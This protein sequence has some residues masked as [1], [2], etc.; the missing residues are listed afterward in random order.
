MKTQET[1]R[2]QTSIVSLPGFGRWGC[3]QFGNREGAEEARG[4]NGRVTCLLNAVAYTYE[5]AFLHSV[6]S[7]KQRTTPSPRYLSCNSGAGVG[8]AEMLASVASIPYVNARSK[9]EFQRQARDFLFSPAPNHLPTISP[10]RTPRLLASAAALHPL[11]TAELTGAEEGA[12]HPRLVK[13]GGEVMMLAR[14][15][16]H[17]VQV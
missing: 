16:P 12:L 9:S 6:S 13:E 10:P 11:C 7:I 17:A 15:A 8:S 14:L 3:S 4:D 2:P 1:K 5:K